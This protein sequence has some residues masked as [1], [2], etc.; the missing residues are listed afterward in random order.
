MK[1]FTKVVV[2]FG[3]LILLIFG[4]F[5]F[6]NWFSRTTGYV[7]GEDEKVK[8]AQCLEG[9]D[10]KFYVSNTC[11]SCETQKEIFGETAMRFIEVVVCGNVEDCPIG[12]V[13]AWEID[14]SI[15]YGFKDLS[16]LIEISGC[17]VE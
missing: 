6:S 14:G 8:L 3:F 13:P 1:Q 15:Y 7:L 10:T 9:E 16:E 5:T 12:G 4:L 11:P 17:L 2:T